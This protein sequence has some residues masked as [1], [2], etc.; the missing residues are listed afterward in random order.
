MKLLKTIYKKNIE[1]SIRPDEIR[2]SLLELK[3]LVQ[4]PLNAFQFLEL[5]IYWKLR[6]R[7]NKVSR[8]QSRAG[9]NASP[10]QQGVAPLLTH[11]VLYMAPR[12]I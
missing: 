8:F 11:L 1:M 2:I 12:I 10:Q 9:Q 7:K 3:E 4:C 6:T 5:C